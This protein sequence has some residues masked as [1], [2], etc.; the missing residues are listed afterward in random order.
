MFKHHL[1]LIYRNF[2]RYKS[3]FFIN[4]IGLSAGLSCALLIY[5]WVN[6]EMQIDRFHNERL[7]QVIQKEHLT[8]GVQTVEGTPGILAETMAKELREVETAVA[9]SPGFWLGQSKVSANHKPA[10]KAAGKFAGPD[11]FKVFSY[12]L[13]TGNINEVLTGKKTVVI[14]ESIA[15]KLFNST[16]VVGKR[17]GME[18]Y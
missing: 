3:S 1:L 6:N 15:R 4:L 7:Y 8:D 16:D 9:T 5:L 11:F 2:K 18:Q 17:N 14:S 12:P 10:I 13:I